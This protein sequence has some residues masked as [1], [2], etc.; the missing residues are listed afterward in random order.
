MQHSNFKT[1][2]ISRFPKI[3]FSLLIASLVVA[4]LIFFGSNTAQAVTVNLTPS[5]ASVTQG[6]DITFT[7]TVTIQTSERIPINS[8]SLALF[9]DSGLTSELSSSPYS[10][11]RS[12]AQTDVDPYTGYYTNGSNYGVPA[13]SRYRNSD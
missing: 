11:P 8:V 1:I 5:S 6:N 2:P 4:V 13:K 12:M 3:I 7:T 9:S 10:S